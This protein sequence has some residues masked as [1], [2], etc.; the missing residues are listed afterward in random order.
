MKQKINCNRICELGSFTIYKNKYRNLYL[1][2]LMKYIF[3]IST[4][5]KDGFGE[6]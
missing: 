2:V 3:E 6:L 1:E 4:G 5:K